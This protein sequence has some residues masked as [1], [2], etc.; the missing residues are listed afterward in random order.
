MER[1]LV[2][3]VLPI[4]NVEKY[5]DRCIISVVNQS[6]RELEI[7]LIDDGSPDNCPAI[8]ENWVHK[9]PRIKVLHK[10]NSGLGFARNS[11]IELATGKYICF[12]DSDDY[13]EPDTIASCVDA[14]EQEKADIVCFGNDVRTQ[15]GRVLSQRIPTPPRLLFIGE[16]V[17]K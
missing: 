17:R 15:D 16:A 2:S 3:V 14:A 8:C 9:D 7:I 5:L 10:Q 4:Y 1:P 13:I 12:F 6:Y 11:G